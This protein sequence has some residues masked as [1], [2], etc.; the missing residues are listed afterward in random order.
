LDGA[1]D[2][3][4]YPWPAKEDSDGIECQKEGKKL[5]LWEAKDGNYGVTH[6]SFLVSQRRR[7][8]AETREQR[9]N[10]DPRR[11]NEEEMKRPNRNA[12][13]LNAHRANIK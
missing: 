9:R 11:G 3:K 13:V 1:T 2:E 5:T 4:L 6:K 10:S 8:L 7:V 12:V